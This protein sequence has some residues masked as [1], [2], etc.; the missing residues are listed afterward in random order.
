MKEEIKR[1]YWI[2][3][4]LWYEI[5]YINGK[6]HGLSKGWYFNGQLYFETKL[7]NHLEHGTKIEFN[8]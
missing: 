6:A 2:N 8:Y 3:R 5:P 1:E 7:K 4:H